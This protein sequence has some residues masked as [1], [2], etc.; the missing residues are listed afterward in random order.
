MWRITWLFFVHAEHLPNQISVL[1][2][3]LFSNSK[4]SKL[5]RLASLFWKKNKKLLVTSLKLST[6]PLQWSDL[7]LAK[8]LV[9][10]LYW[11]SVSTIS[12]LNKAPG[13]LIND[14]GSCPFLLLP[15][16]AHHLPLLLEFSFPVMSQSRSLWR[17]IWKLR[18]QFIQSLKS[19][20]L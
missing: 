20:P 3:W 9:K 13:A 5:N 15:A 11:S 4:S 14:N 19:D 12:L 2:G 8:V 1:W 18:F 7:V 6:P 10:T 16:C 17:L